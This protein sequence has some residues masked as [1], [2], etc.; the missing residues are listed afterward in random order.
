MSID[1][2]KLAQLT[3]EFMSILERDNPDA[4][5]MEVGIV[6]ELRELDDD[7]PSGRVHSPTA[8]TNDS[9]LYQTGL[10]QWALDSVQWSGGPSDE[11]DPPDERPATE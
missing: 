6:V 3:Q 7:N 9:R 2:M 10:F 5:L 11:A 8:C 4:E 1:T